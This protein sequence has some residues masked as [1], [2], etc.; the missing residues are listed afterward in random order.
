[1][2]KIFVLDTNVILHDSRC[3]FNFQ[4]N[5]IVIP[6]T[7]LEEIDQFKRGQDPIN[8]HARD[9]IRILDEFSGAT[10]L[11]LGSNA[12]IYIDAISSILYLEKTKIST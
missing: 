3:I 7:V 5:H 10:S 12:N 9:F 11:M 6:I 1:L 2:E 4:D 8:F